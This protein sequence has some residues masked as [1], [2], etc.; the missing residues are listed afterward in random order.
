M[1]SLR[2]LSF[3]GA[4]LLFV[5]SIDGAS[6][7]SN[8]LSRIAGHLL[9]T[10]KI[11]TSIAPTA[12]TAEAPKKYGL[13]LAKK[14]LPN[15]YEWIKTKLIP[16]EV[17]AKIDKILSD[18]EVRS[19]FKIIEFFFITQARNS[20]KDWQEWESYIKALGEQELYCKA[21]LKQLGF[22]ILKFPGVVMHKDLP[23]YVIKMSFSGSISSSI[24]HNIARVW[25]RDWI[26][27]AANCHGR[28]D[29]R[30]V[31]K[32]IYCSDQPLQDYLAIMVVAKHINMYGTE[33]IFNSVASYKPLIFIA[34]VC[35][36]PDAAMVG[37]NAKL[38]DD[39]LWSLDTEPRSRND[40]LMTIFRNNPFTKFRDVYPEKP[41][42]GSSCEACGKSLTLA[43]PYKKSVQA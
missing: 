15:H 38:I 5:P 11:D 29:V 4:L 9:A 23:G 36:I 31:E 37:Q 21:Q 20:F 41:E 34:D 28:K 30:C 10:P 3:L 1:K 19:L 7:A 32:G 25:G 42:K 26:E 2:I 17:A 13:Q 16:E 39:T 33:A 24:L 27:D 22:T 40:E 12:A 14:I 6:T 8:R 18:P 35:K 43:T